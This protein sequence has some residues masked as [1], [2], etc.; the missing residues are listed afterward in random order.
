MFYDI[1]LA[2]ALNGN[3]GGGGGGG[4]K[5]Y[6]VKDGIIQD[7]YSFSTVKTTVTEKTDGDEHYL[8]LMGTVL[9]DYQTVYTPLIF[10][11][12]EN[13]LV[14][15]EFAKI[16]GKYGQSWNNS[17]T[18]PSF[19]IGKSATADTIPYDSRI[20][21]NYVNSGTKDMMK[22]KY[23]IGIPYDSTSVSIKFSL[24]GEQAFAGCLYIKNLYFYDINL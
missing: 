13:S 11:P 6:I 24:S 7:G 1:L 16:S 15:V 3:G 4:T 9:N 20:F 18:Y 14:V 22:E 10:V 23:I 19:S 5:T 21:M 17:V 8:E 12:S 2:K